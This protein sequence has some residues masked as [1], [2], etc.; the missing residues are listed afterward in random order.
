MPHHDAHLSEDTRTLPNVT[1]TTA[2]ASAAPPSL[3]PDGRPVYLDCNATTPLDP[4]VRDEVL[5]YLDEEYGNAG[6]RTHL[7]GQAAKDRVNQARAE[8][9]AV[10]ACQPDEVAFSSGAT[11]S[12]NLALL[13]LARHGTQVGR[14]HLI[15]TMIEHKAVLEPLEA[16]RAD[17]FEITLIKPNEGGRVSPEQVAAALRPDT[18]AVSVMAVNNET[19][20]IQPIPEIANILSGHDA[21]LHVDGAQGFGKTIDLLRHPRIDL[22]SISGH[23]IYGPKG[24]GALITRRRGYKR[25]PLHPLAFGGGQERGLRPGTLPV[26]LIAGVGAAARLALR[27][28][29][30]RAQHCAAF[31]AE[32]LDA[33]ALLQPQLNGD[34]GH[35]VPHTVNLSI[36]GLDAEAAML[37]TK[38]LIAV[39]NGSACTSA[40]Y[41]P[42]HVLAAMGL[43]E[44]RVRGAL[45]ISWCHLTPSPD[46][47][48]VVSRLTRVSPMPFRRA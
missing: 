37:A 41:E 46:W 5:R 27:D 39:S 12:N 3:P 35:T 16:L 13:G 42:S 8:V 45:R 44:D 7:Y 14:R 9:A 22:I 11:E 34:P 40:R 20:V 4:E 33:L 2:T 15:S 25:P 31:K 21:Y 32:L 36:S 43:P 38:D 23:K 6:S 48:A 18:L 17:G 24:V 1:I 10:V 30:K 29:D 47:R 26:P 28:H 19:G